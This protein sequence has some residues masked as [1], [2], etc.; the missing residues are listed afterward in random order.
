MDRR[1]PP[2]ARPASPSSS[3]RTPTTSPAPS[4]SARSI[5]PGSAAPGEP[6]ALHL[7]LGA[8]TRRSPDES[9]ATGS[10]TGLLRRSLLNAFIL[11][12]DSIRRS[13]RKSPTGPPRLVIA[14]AQACLRGGALRHPCR[15]QPS[16]AGGV[17]ATAGTSMASC[18]TRSS[19]PSVA[20]WSTATGLA[21]PATWPGSV[22]TIA[23]YTSFPGAPTSSFSTRREEGG[24]GEEG[25]VIVT[26]L[27]TGRCR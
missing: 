20:R 14:Y 23:A 18:A 25:E 4:R 27:Q 11:T 6:G 26:G 10:A 12:D 16:A 5:R 8:Q 17:I 3:F 7:G 1:T 22:C 19:R 13:S 2:A 15:N 9:C 24:G 21:R